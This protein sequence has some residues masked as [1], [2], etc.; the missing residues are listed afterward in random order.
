MKPHSALKSRL[1]NMAVCLRRS[2]CSLQQGPCA[3]PVPALALGRVPHSQTTQHHNSRSVLPA[4]A[5]VS[6]PVMLK[7]LPAGLLPAAVGPAAAD[8]AVAVAATVQIEGPTSKPDLDLNV[9]LDAAMQPG[10]F[11]GPVAVANIPGVLSSSCM[12]VSQH[13]NQCARRCVVC[14][15]V[16]LLYVVHH[17]VFA[18]LCIGVSCCW[19]MLQRVAAKSSCLVL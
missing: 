16:F 13:Y 15:Q 7:Q 2:C 9:Y 10:H 4:A 8:R 5:A 12:H 1:P 18:S 3:T 6:C 17:A 11:V 19:H 14:M